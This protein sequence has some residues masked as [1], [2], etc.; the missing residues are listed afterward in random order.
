VGSGQNAIE[1]I[2]Y[3]AEA[4]PESRI[5]SINH[6]HGFRMYDL[7][8][9]SNEVYF[10]EE[11]D[12]F[13]SLSRESRSQMFDEVR[14]TNYSSVDPD[15]SRA[16]YLRVYEDR[17][18]GESRIKV[19]KRARVVDVTF[20]EGAYQI[21]LEE[22][23]LHTQQQLQADAIILCTGFSEDHV[24]AYLKPILPYLCFEKDE[25]LV[26]TRDYRVET[27]PTFKPQIYVNGISELTHG[28]SDSTSF[29]MMALKAGRIYQ[30]LTGAP[31]HSN[32]AARTGKEVHQYETASSF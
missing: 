15:V 2:L 3:L 18:C 12:Y 32:G 9:F 23:F 11:V 7:G 4:F 13:Y 27:G 20:E 14:L 10:P 1:I 26:V 24:P 30:G 8:H 6:N 28:I 29:S 21:L 22:R 16:L 31:P 17:V 25:T 19:L 5:L